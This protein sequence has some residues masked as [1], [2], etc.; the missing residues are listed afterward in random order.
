V[1]M[2]VTVSGA[3]TGA[4]YGILAVAAFPR[5]LPTVTSGT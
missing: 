4:I 5:N 3:T 1:R 2:V